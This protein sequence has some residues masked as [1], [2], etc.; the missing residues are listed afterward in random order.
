MVKPEMLHTGGSY[1]STSKIDLGDQISLNITIQSDL[2]EKA[3][4]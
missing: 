4:N 2:I 3:Y 1:K